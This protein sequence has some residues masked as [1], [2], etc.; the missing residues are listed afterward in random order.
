MDFFKSFWNFL[1]LKGVPGRG[2]DERAGK[3]QPEPDQ[4]RRKPR[5][6][7]SKVNG[8]LALRSLT[9]FLL[10]MLLGEDLTLFW[11]VLFQRGHQD[12]AAQ[13]P[14]RGERG[15]RDPQLVRR[16]P[17]LHEQDQSADLRWQLL[18]YKKS[19]C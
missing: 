10:L 14:Q 17:H 19:T 16:A 11:Q 5:G 9:L 2:R 6:R 15:D 18:V 1:L 8:K 4:L 13:L 3:H 7:E 12:G